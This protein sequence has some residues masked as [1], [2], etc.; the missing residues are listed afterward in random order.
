MLAHGCRARH[1]RRPHV[2]LM[3][4]CR[5]PQT[6]SR[7]KT[8]V[9]GIV[10][11]TMQLVVDPLAEPLRREC[12]SAHAAASAPELAQPAGLSTVASPQSPALL[13]SDAGAQSMSPN[14]AWDLVFS[15]QSRH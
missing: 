14:G 6:G 15:R 1:V 13:A 5:G 11:G 2:L 7:L 12:Q 4:A 10:E 3:V 8:V 9:A